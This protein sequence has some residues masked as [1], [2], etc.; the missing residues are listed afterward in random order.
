MNPRHQIKI[1]LSLALICCCFYLKTSGQ[2]FS[3]RRI[4]LEEGLSQSSIMAIAQDSR[5]FLWFG[6]QDGLNRYDGYDFSVLKNEPFDPNSLS[7]NHIRALLIDRQ[8]VL[9]V[10]TGGGG[11]NIYNPEN[12]S[13]TRLQYSPEDAGS[14]S[15]NYITTIYQDLDGTIWIGTH[16]GLNKVVFE[17]D[18]PLENEMYLERFLYNANRPRIAFE[19]SIQSIYRDSEG[20]LWIGTRSGLY[21]QS[22]GDSGDTFKSWF[23]RNTEEN[24]WKGMPILQIGENANYEL[25]VS[26]A[27]GMYQ[28][29]RENQEFLNMPMPWDNESEPESPVV[30]FFRQGKNGDMLIGVEGNGV[31]LLK[32]DGRK[33]AYSQQFFHLAHQ[34]D[35]NSTISDNWLYTAEEDRFQKGSWWIGTA[36]GGINFIQEKAKPFYPHFFDNQKV[37]SH[38]GTYIRTT[39]IDKNND[40]WFSLERGI[41][42]HTTATG[43]YQYFEYARE[44]NNTLKS[45]VIYSTLEDMSGQIW[46]GTH[47]GL[48]KVINLSGGRTG[49]QYFPYPEDCQIGLSFSLEEWQ[50]GKI[51]LGTA[52]GLNLF[53]PAT[54]L[55]QGCS[56]VLDTLFGLQNGYFITDMHEDRKGNFWVATTKGLVFIKNITD[57]LNGVS[58]I[59]PKIFRHNPN[60]SSSLRNDAVNSLA[61]DNEGNMWLGTMN[62]LIKVELEDEEW[63]FTSFTE[64]NGL[65]NNVVYAVIADSITKSL[66]MST[67]NGLSKL[68]LSLLKFDNY[69]SRDGL[70][71]SEFNQGAF[72]RTRDGQFIFGGIGGYTRFFPSQIQRDPYPPKVYLT[73]FSGGDGRP[74]NLLDNSG[75]QIELNFTEN[76][77][78]LE[79]VGLNFSDPKR[80]SYSYRLISPKNEHEIK[81]I[82]AGTNRQVNITNLSPGKYIFEVKATNG[83]GIASL[84]PATLKIRIHP[85]FWRTV[86]FYLLLITGITGLL[87][88]F[89]WYRVKVKVRRV[90][91]LERVRKSTAADFHDEL[92]HKLTIISLFGE[93]LKKQLNDKSDKIL[94]HL[95]KIISTSNSLYY[96]MKDLLWVLDPEKDSILDL[97]ILL[98]DFG[99]ELFDKTGIGFRTEG[100]TNEM[101]NYL[102]SMEQKRHI[103]LIFKEAMNNTL[104][105]SA[106]RN[107]V[108]SVE[109][110]EE[111][112]ILH[113]EDDG[114]GFDLEKANHGHGL[115]NL[116]ER[117]EKLGSELEI[118]SNQS[119]TQVKL[120]GELP[121]V[122]KK[123]GKRRI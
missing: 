12:Q 44:G 9:W 88:F 31:A 102:L 24:G 60:D 67:N 46:F 79:Y 87:W 101:E 56:I 6:T 94:P 14:L 61:E 111:K 53:D 80:N 73:H 77:F 72:S 36:L 32:Y 69:D 116:R 22:K 100:I 5:G 76:T 63:K 65:A 119:G 17:G 98:K 92:G 33:K 81:W 83:D 20:T 75:D 45:P 90:M 47:R 110:D 120:I 93:I 2:E 4:G 117:A 107:A 11:M 23:R 115:T 118:Q 68:D 66:W 10:G 97:V 59:S 82:H 39:L 85:P 48:H 30:N 58:G 38:S 25:W 104:K 19:S 29:D 103:V 106:C 64:K 71:G 89:H 35:Q 74:R 108:L 41:V 54:E 112:L 43:E 52:G 26:T 91:E 37:P 96:S 13:F 122:M 27:M 42:K 78:T 3:S 49:F 113:F 7:H 51:L 55:Y 21:S 57:L 34:P 84:S 50:N 86:W 99:D 28:F 40:V 8:D 16:N 62:G 70:Q 1:L 109:I 95:D 15:N 18:H 123:T 121:E 114:N 105:H